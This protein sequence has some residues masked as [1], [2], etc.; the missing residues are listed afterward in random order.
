MRLEDFKQQIDECFAKLSPEDVISNLEKLGYEFE[1]L[2]IFDEYCINS[3]KKTSLYNSAISNEEEL[4]KDFFAMANI[5]KT[6]FNILESLPFT[7]TQETT[8]E[9]KDSK[10]KYAEAA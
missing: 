5:N 6:S 4:Q 8:F 9:D 10:D 3:P 2:D 1:P 7:S